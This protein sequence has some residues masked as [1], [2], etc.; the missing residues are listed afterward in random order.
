MLPD[1]VRRHTI[2]NGSGMYLTLSYSHNCIYAYRHAIAL[3]HT[4]RHTHS[5]TSTHTVPHMHENTHIYIYTVQHIF[6][7]TATYG[8]VK[9]GKTE[10]GVKRNTCIQRTFM[11]Q[12]INR[13]TL[14]CRTL[15]YNHQRIHACK[16]FGLTV[17]HHRNTAH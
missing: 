11:K 2:S 7:Y 13:T 9:R 16:T 15:R 3:A 8:R 4:H 1:I 10:R 14:Y 6:I 12:G 17:Y 5:H